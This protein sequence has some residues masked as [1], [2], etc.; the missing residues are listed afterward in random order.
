[1]FSSLTK[2][3]PRCNHVKSLSYL[4][5]ISN[6]VTHPLN[7]EKIHVAS[8][9]LSA[10]IL[11]GIPFQLNIQVTAEISQVT[12]KN[13]PDSIDTKIIFAYLISASQPKDAIDTIDDCIKSSPE[14]AILSRLYTFKGSVSR[15]LNKDCEQFFITALELDQKNTSAMFCLLQYL[16]FKH[17][18]KGRDPNLSRRILQI[19]NQFISTTFNQDHNDNLEDFNPIK[20]VIETN[21]AECDLSIVLIL[22][23]IA[24][25][26]FRRGPVPSFPELYETLKDISKLIYDIGLQD[27]AAKETR[28]S[29]DTIINLVESI[30]KGK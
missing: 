27:D 25:A 12:L 19:S 20:K 28:T 14:N 29:V 16:S 13:Y 18:E 15:L 8:Q 10:L 7:I 4:E 17:S 3:T 24:E 30:S 9:Y 22:G 5:L 11:S 2:E 1:M 6:S 26:Y 23:F 21:I